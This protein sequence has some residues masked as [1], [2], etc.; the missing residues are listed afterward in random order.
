MYPI[1]LRCKRF[2]AVVIVVI[3]TVM[4]LIFLGTYIIVTK[5][6]D[7]ALHF[8]PELAAISFYQSINEE[9]S[10][11]GSLQIIFHSRYLRIRR[12]VATLMF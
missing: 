4:H 6:I 3:S 10:T 11:S 7:V 9:I 12:K 1:Q 5:H 8:R 2:F